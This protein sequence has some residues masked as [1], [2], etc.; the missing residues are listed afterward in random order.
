[1]S[2][3]DFRSRSSKLA[4][5]TKKKPD[6]YSII[7]QIDKNITNYLKLD[8]IDV[9]NV[10]VNCKENIENKLFQVTWI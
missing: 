8:E 4:L 10:Q 1:M 7:K 2:T 5:K 3:G 9:F 6:Q